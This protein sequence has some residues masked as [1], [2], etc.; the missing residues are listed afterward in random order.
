MFDL[1]IHMTLTGLWP[2]VR[3]VHRSVEVRIRLPF[4]SLSCWPAKQVK[5][6]NKKSLWG[7]DHRGSQTSS[8][9]FKYLRHGSNAKQPLMSCF[10][11]WSQKTII[12]I[13]HEMNCCT[14]LI[15]PTCS[16]QNPVGCSTD[17][18]TVTTLETPNIYSMLRYS[19]Y[20]FQCIWY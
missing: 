12:C 18:N 3:L 16:A 17:Q 4:G 6:N 1:W 8:V 13:T 10:G 14:F 11:S 20:V 7:P 19:L 9:T 5:E 15:H 2:A